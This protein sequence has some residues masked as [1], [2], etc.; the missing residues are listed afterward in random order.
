MRCPRYRT[1]EPFGI[2]V[3]DVSYELFTVLTNHGNFPIFN[4][5]HLQGQ[6]ILCNDFFGLRV[7]AF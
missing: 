3:N 7:N 2:W 1:A 6:I 5:E 4:F